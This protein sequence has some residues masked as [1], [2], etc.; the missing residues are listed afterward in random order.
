[1]LPKPVSVAGE[2]HLWDW[3]YHLARFLC[4]M[5]LQLCRREEKQNSKSSITCIRGGAEE[6]IMRRT[7][8]RVLAYQ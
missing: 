4:P 1:M 5:C 7:P 2:N 3:K 8:T 6:A